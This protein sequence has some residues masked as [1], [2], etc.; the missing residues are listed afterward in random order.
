MED[1]GDLEKCEV[2]FFCFSINSRLLNFFSG[3]SGFEGFSVTLPPFNCEWLCA[4]VRT[5]LA[6]K[7]FDGGLG[8]LEFAQILSWELLCFIF[9]SNVVLVSPVIKWKI[10]WTYLKSSIN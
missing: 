8:D 6:F 4:L 3:F 10:T 5:P 1:L 7:W 2:Q 9:S